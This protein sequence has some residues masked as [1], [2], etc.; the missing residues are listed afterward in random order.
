L[1]LRLIEPI[2]DS[3][4]DAV[5][6]LDGDGVVVGWNE[7]ATLTFGWTAAEAIGRSMGD[8]IVPLQ[9]REAHRAGME[10]YR[11]TG[12]ARVVNRRIEI[13]GPGQDWP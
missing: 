1:P 10:R 7:V 6:V 5:V 12:E 2:L 3:M 11:A 9:H 13:T 8:L 4:L